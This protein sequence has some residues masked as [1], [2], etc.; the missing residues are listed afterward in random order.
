VLLPATADDA[1]YQA[2]AGAFVQALAESGWS[3][4]RNLSIDTRWTTANA[5][6]I[7]RHAAELVALAPVV[8]LAPGA[9]TVGPLLQ[10]TRTVPT[11]ASGLSYILR[12][13]AYIRSSPATAPRQASVAERPVVLPPEIQGATVM[14]LLFQPS[15]PLF[16]PSPPPC[17]NCGTTTVIV[18]AI[19]EGQRI[20]ATRC[21][22]CGRSARYSLNYS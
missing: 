5:D 19:E 7:R 10:V 17:A 21:P 15:P 3:V 8:I 4:D 22:A 12:N 16:Q 11:A 9:S 13:D 1:Q 20:F 18:P 6:A 14:S 2:W